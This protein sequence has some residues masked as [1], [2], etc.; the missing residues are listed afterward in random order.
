MF[1]DGNTIY[2]AWPEGK[3]LPAVLELGSDGKTET[4]VNYTTKGQH[5][6]IEGFRSRL[7]LRV[8]RENA[9]LET[10]R[11]GPVRPVGPALSMGN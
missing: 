10:E 11:R 1:D 7:V 2:L 5:I 9:V 8:G 4:P 6:V 3:D